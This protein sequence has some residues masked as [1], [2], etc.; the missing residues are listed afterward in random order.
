MRILYVAHRLPY[1]PD[2]GAKIRSFHHL[3]SLCASH[4]VHLVSLAEQQD[5]AGPRGEMCRS[6]E[7]LSLP[8]AGAWGRAARALAGSGS[9]SAAYFASPQLRRAVERATASAD[10]D[11]AWAS[12]SAIAP[13]LQ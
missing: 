2:A 9:L 3:R 6:V 13:L 1:P 12:S 10:F 11:V 8:R 7:R 5:S 4:D